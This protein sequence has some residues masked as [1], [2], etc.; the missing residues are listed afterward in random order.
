MVLVGLFVSSMVANSRHTTTS[1]S[2]IASR[3]G[4]AVDEPA[5]MPHMMHPYWTT[6][7]IIVTSCL[8]K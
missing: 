4:L 6:T 3:L 7:Q 1:I 8:T 5:S 2:P